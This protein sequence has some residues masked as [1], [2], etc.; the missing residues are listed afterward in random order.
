[1]CGEL[2]GGW[3]DH[4]GEHHHVRSVESMMGTVDELLGAN[5]SVSLYMA[6]GG[7]NFGLWAGANHDGVIQPTVTSY[8][9]D[10]PIGEDGRVGDKFAALR[11][12]FARAR[13]ITVDEL[14]A[15][16]AGPSF[17]PESAHA[18]SGAGSLLER[19]RGLAFGDRSVQPLS[20]ERLGVEAG[21]VAY[22]AEA[23]IPAGETVTVRGLRDRAIVFFRGVRVATLE[24]DGE[25]TFTLDESGSGELL[26]AVESLGRINYGPLVGEHKGILDG[27]TIQRRFV[28]G[29]EHA[30]LVGADAPGARSEGVVAA[31]IDVTEPA[32]AWLAFPGGRKGFVWLNGFLLGRYWER[33]PQVTLYAPAPLWRAGANEI[34]VLD[35]DAE[36]T[37]IAVEVR[38]EPEFGPVEEFIGV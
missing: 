29:W 35:V 11:M 26:I 38:Q 19:M 31:S 9:S 34:V 33:G 32:D 2:W 23:S 18:L 4:W 7:T 28:H 36:G 37:D 21:I 25:H 27:V 3:F 15:L 6:H 30:V 17:L 12:A 1:M 13:G 5:G 24:H 16:P 20:F 8:D 10:A 22:R 14:P